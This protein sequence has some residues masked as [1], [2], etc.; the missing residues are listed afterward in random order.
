MDGINTLHNVFEYFKTVANRLGNIIVIA[1]AMLIGFLIG[2]YY[3]LMFAKA[4]GPKV[5]QTMSSVS[6]A[7]ND[8]G[9][10]MIIDRANGLYA[11]YQD[12]VGQAIFNLYASEKYNKIVK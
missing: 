6:I 4:N 5:A 7:I 8:R 12:S 1:S 9:E 3:W 10:L 2:Y 11:I